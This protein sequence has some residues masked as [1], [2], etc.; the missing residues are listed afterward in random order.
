[1][2]SEKSER[3]VNLVIALLATKKFL[4]KNQIFSAVPGYEGTPESKDRMFER[5][6]EELR[7]IGINLE[8]KSIDPLFE[9]EIGYRILPERFQLDLAGL[10]PSE[11][12]L[13]A[14]ANEVWRES[15]LNGVANSTAIRLES[16]GIAADFSE[17]DLIP[18]LVN[19]PENLYSLFATLENGK[20]IEFQYLN[21]EESLEKRLV[22]PL[23]IYSQ[24]GRWYLGA[25][26]QEKR[27]LRTFRIDRIVGEVKRTQRNF[28][29]V[30]FKVPQSF[31]PELEVLFKLRRDRALHLSRGAQLIKDEGDWLTYKKNFESFD[32]AKSEILRAGSDAQA[33]QPISLVSDITK[34]ITELI[35]LHD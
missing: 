4:T 33:L 24:R 13:L 6:K 3:L 14:L 32:A 5:D 2:A 27:E 12:S 1:M 35:S 7:S 16:L 21:S 19:V 8:M 25:I 26:D 10:T 18:N 17:I 20:V 15:A 34:S 22:G 9:D 23:S 31:F 30:P 29:R 11:I 28:E